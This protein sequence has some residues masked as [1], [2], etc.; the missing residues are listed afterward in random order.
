MRIALL[1]AAALLA[2][3]TSP[4]VAVPQVGLGVPAALLDDGPLPYAPAPGASDTAVAYWIAALGDVGRSCLAHQA[5]VRALLQSTGN[6]AAP[7]A[8]RFIP[9]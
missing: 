5:E 8:G 6:V 3:C 1:M 2:G 7:A 9:H 4:P